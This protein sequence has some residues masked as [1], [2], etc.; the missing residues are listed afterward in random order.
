MNG[1]NIKMLGK[2]D[3]LLCV[4][5]LGNIWDNIVSEPNGSV[6]DFHNLTCLTLLQIFVN[7]TF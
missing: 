5:L 4:I 1:A 3:V 7:V 2:D 6:V